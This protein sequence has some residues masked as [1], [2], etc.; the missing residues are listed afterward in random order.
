MGVDRIEEGSKL[1]PATERKNWTFQ[2][3]VDGLVL[4]GKMDLTELA[5]VLQLPDSDPALEANRVS[6]ETGLSGLYDITLKWSPESPTAPPGPTLFRAIED[7]LG[8]KLEP[9]HTPT[10]MLIVDHAEKVP[11]GN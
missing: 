7:Q 2:Y 10:Q 11:T 3:M 1:R 9:R 5:F 8:L 6:D 4:T